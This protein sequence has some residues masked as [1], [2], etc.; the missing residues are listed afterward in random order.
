MNYK[1]F[2]FLTLFLIGGTVRAGTIID[3]EC[4]SFIDVAQG[5]TYRA[6]SDGLG[7]GGSW[8]KSYSSGW[9]NIKNFGNYEIGDK[10]EYV[11]IEIS[12]TPV[13]KTNGSDKDVAFF[14]AHPSDK[15]DF[16][17]PVHDNTGKLGE[18]NPIARCQK[19]G[20][21]W[22]PFQKVNQFSKF[23]IRRQQC[24][25][26]KIDP[27]KV[28]IHFQYSGGHFIQKDSTTWE[29]H[30]PTFTKRG[31]TL[32]LEKKEASNII[33]KGDGDVYAL[34]KDRVMKKDGNDWKVLT[35]EGH[36]VY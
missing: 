20:G 18:V 3:S 31:G 9:H 10:T 36:W 5:H 21:R 33:L 26:G 13:T 14:C 7:D 11:L 2:F 30:N 28:R 25:P 15:F 29:Y 4:D 12:G 1:A 27:A 19:M 6:G 24:Q 8:E 34:Q 35:P 17:L 23:T 16:T 32:Y 22:R